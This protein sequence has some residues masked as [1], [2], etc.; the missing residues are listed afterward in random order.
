MLF[1]LLA[2]IIWT[3]VSFLLR[4]SMKTL[5]DLVCMKLMCFCRLS[6]KR[7]SQMLWGQSNTTR[8]IGVELLR[9]LLYT[10]GE[11]RFVICVYFLCKMVGESIPV[12]LLVVYQK[13]FPT[14]VL[15]LC[16]LLYYN[17]YRPSVD[18]P[19]VEDRC[20]AKVGNKEVLKTAITHNAA[21]SQTWKM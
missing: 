15:C 16:P 3:P 13:L 9:S 20:K 4:R 1:I 10:D 6:L 21:Q 18:G 5:P 2:T 17:S 19:Q 8:R 12:T 11:S 7:N 14:C